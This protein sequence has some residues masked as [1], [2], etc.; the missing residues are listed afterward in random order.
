MMTDDELERM[1]RRY[2]PNPASWPAPQRQLAG[3]PA[4]DDP[5][6]RLVLDAA[7]DGV[8]EVPPRALEAIKERSGARAI[9]EFAFVSRPMATA[10]IALFGIALVSGYQIAGRNQAGSALFDL[11]TGASGAF[12]DNLDDET[13][14]KI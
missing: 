7:I 2:G 8:G 4:G 9:G 6:D 3:P 11:A 1:K 10:A 13:G 14:R 12:G 5:L